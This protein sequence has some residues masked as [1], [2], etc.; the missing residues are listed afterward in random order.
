MR[1]TAF[2]GMFVCALIATSSSTASA[3]S[4]GLLQIDKPGNPFPAAAITDQPER[5]DNSQPDEPNNEEK[6]AKPKSEPEPVKVPAKPKVQKYTVEKHDTLSTIAKDHD[7]DWVDLFNKNTD[8]DHPDII[9]VG[10]ELV[11]PRADENL[12]ERPLP[13]PPQVQ[14]SA[15][16][17]QSGR[18]STRTQGAQQQSRSATASQRIQTRGSS[19]GNLYSRGYCTWYAKNRR[20][21][22]P[23]NLGNANTW[24]VRAR[25][26]GIATG[27]TPRVGAIGQRGMHVVYV[28]SV[29]G[30]GTVTISEM[31]FK[32][33]YVKST[34]TVAASSFTYIY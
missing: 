19:S 7:T 33:L 23:N 10:D 28:E 9:N 6:A 14:E 4:L 17:A 13:E 11:I 5:S 2:A 3:Q 24:A 1:I 16:A 22:L 30:N 29:N 15:T 18:N 20:P 34:R 32:G 27:S 31:N 8:I 12:E 26:Q 25:A 21:D